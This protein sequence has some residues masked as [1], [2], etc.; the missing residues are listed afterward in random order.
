MEPRLIA[1][2]YDQYIMLRVSL[3][4]TYQMYL[5][6]Y[7]NSKKIHKDKESMERRIYWLR[8]ARLSRV[9][10]NQVERTLSSLK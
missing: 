3:G 6:M 9:T 8:K 5:D 4:Y 2:Q 7:R 10:Y 1:L